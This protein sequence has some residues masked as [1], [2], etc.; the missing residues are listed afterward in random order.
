MTRPE[1]WCGDPKARATHRRVGSTIPECTPGRIGEIVLQRTAEGVLVL[2]ADA[3]IEVSD[4][5]LDRVAHGQLV[6]A[7]ELVE[8]DLLVIDALNG[9]W[10]YRLTGSRP[11]ANTREAVLLDGPLADVL[12]ERGR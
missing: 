9:Q 12:K 1:C 5:L 4:V 7:V 8:E 10:V 6:D 11:T 3:R 2:R